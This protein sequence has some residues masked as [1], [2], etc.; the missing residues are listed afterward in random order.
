MKRAQ[1]LALAV[2]VFPI[3]LSAD[4]KP[5]T[6][7][8]ALRI[9]R[10]SGFDLLIADASV[11][12]AEGDLT[13]AEAISSPSLSLA[14]GTT[15]HY[16]AALCQGCSNTAVSAA[17]TDQAAISD[18][19]SG[20]RRLRIAV[21]RAVL[22]IARRSRADVERT[23]EFTVKEQTLDA[24]LAKRSLG[25]ATE[26]QRLAADTLNLVNVRYAAGAV[27]EADVARA[28]V[29]KLEAD[30]AVDVARQA[31][32]SAKA[33]LAFLLGYRGV[34]PGFD[35]DDD[36]TRSHPII[37]PG[38]SSEVLLAQALTHRPDVAAAGIQIE[39]ARA[40]LALTRRGRIPDLFPSASYAQEGTSQ[41]AIQPPTVTLGLSLTLPA[42]HRNRG[43]V[44]KAE[45]DLRAQQVAAE[46]TASL[47]AS[48]VATAVAA[49]AS[50][51]DRTER[52]E[53]RLLARSERARDL[54]RLQYEKGAASLFEFLD[55]QRTFIA[56]Q[57]EYL[58]TLND[59]WTAVFQ[60]EQATG[61]EVRP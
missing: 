17:I 36:L 34:P 18:M 41:S 53:D 26:S 27:S 7:N 59:Y 48:D 4:Q 22:D 58:Q 8:D 54:V 3:T 37:F 42:L 44:T 50:A 28:E 10:S 21:A 49:F 1:A 57:S 19:L 47:V 6:L 9:F 38:V 61:M 32:D 33:G 30:Q 43:E 11:A 23:L 29:Q 31:L 20:K 40:A 13:A 15:F 5:L 51:K 52:M 25:Y 35:L 16:D 45:A 24:E 12:A 14:R 56:T 39:R 2:L 60:L 46:K 55:A